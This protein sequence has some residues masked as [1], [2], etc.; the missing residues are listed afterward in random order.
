MSEIG[1]KEQY[2]YLVRRPCGQY[3]HCLFLRTTSATDC[4]PTRYASK[5][6]LTLSVVVMPATGFDTLVTR[7]RLTLTA[8]GQAS[9]GM[10]G[11]LHIHRKHVCLSVRPSNQSRRRML[12]KR[13]TGTEPTTKRR[14][15]WQHSVLKLNYSQKRV[16]IK[17]YAINQER[18]AHFTISTPLSRGSVKNLRL[19][20]LFVFDKLDDI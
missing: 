12:S 9:S 11:T 16:T 10:S 7:T 5:C 1:R 3:D 20:R 17:N 14:A 18:H 15:M 2:V 13:N 6:L 8:S 4:L 19:A